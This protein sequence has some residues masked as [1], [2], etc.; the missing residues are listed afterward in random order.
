MAV[1]YPAAD[2]R[3]RERMMNGKDRDGAPQGPASGSGGAPGAEQEAPSTVLNWMSLVG[4]LF[5]A[6]GF[7]TGL[8][9]ILLDI[10]SLQAKAYT[11][12][13]Y[14]LY[15]L[16]ILIGMIVIPIGMLRER[17]RRR[18]GVAPSLTADLVID[19]RKSSHRTA[20]LVIMAAG[21]VVA[22]AV[23]VGSY[24]SYQATESN[25]FCGQLCH[26]VMHPEATAYE[27][28]S[29]AR[30][31]CVECHIGSGAG[32]YVRSKISGIRQ[33]YAVTFNTFS[34]PIPTPIHDLRPA[35]E[36]C[37][38]CHWPK[39]FIGFRE[40]VRSY[41][42]GNE[43]STPFRMR[44]LMKIGGEE[45][46]LMKGAGI[47]Y[48]MLLANKVEYIARDADRQK[49]AWVRIQNEAGKVTEYQDSD[50]P[51]TDAERAK[52]EVRRM[53]CMDCH[54]RPSHKFPTP[55]H[56]VNQALEVGA[57]PRDLPFAK[58][59]SVRA[60]DE[61]YASTA[62]AMDGIREHMTEYYEENYPDVLK[63]KG[64][65]VAQAVEELQKIYQRSVFPDMK[66]SWKAYPDNI[67][68]RDFPGCFRCH[69][70][71]LQSTDGQT[72]FTDCT[73]CHLIIAE[74]NNVDRVNV[75][76]TKGLPF[77]HPGDDFDPL[78]DYT[79]CTECHD[80]GKE[81]YE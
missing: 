12:I 45:N 39:K 9:T 50:E 55:M 13:L 63:K 15:L 38:Q 66:S 67:G 41:F 74:G 51:L 77:K 53:D 57:I 78:T 61:D 33:I 68:H 34:R 80:G 48:H 11:G 43:E 42:L 2:H 79:D 46:S 6:V 19:F 3:H 22:L 60:L 1:G 52:L 18:P 35:R 72:I 30:V 8:L 31:K 14:L 73:K 36:T 58:L 75:N 25:V 65:E 47:H 81:V 21:A 5:I 64:K 37:E 59:E 69:N 32:W 71:R 40:V 29:H 62:D 26:N 54:N 16:I 49:I 24:Q 23:T 7:G 28:S 10:T 4:V 20:V 70:E 56:I 76:L 17:R 27:Y 44:L